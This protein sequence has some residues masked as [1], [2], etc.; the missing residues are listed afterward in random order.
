VSKFEN[1][2][3][4]ALTAKLGRGKDDISD[5]APVRVVSKFFKAE[6]DPFNKL[7]D[8]IEDCLSMNFSNE[9]IYNKVYEE[10][11]LEPDAYGISDDHILGLADELRRTRGLDEQFDRDR[12]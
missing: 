4:K 8:V 1:S 11:D 10:F 2:L 7:E 6:Q 5:S 9:E 3:D 12:M